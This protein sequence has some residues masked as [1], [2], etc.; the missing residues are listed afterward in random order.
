MKRETTKGR[1][2]KGKGDRIKIKGA[3]KVQKGLK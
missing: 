2:F 3:T 1:N